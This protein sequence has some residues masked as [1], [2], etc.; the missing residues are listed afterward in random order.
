MHCVYLHSTHFH[1]LE[2]LKADVSMI[3]AISFLIYRKRQKRDSLTKNVKLYIKFD[4]IV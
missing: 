3:T 1:E 4:M 2:K